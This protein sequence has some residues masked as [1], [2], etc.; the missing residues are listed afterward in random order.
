MA[1]KKNTRPPSTRASRQN[2]ESQRQRLF[3]AHAIVEV[4]RHAIASQLDGLDEAAITNALQ[5]A[6]GIVDDV[7]A[8][9][10]THTMRNTQ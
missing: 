7:A 2:V 3:Q 4:T 8:A 5:V 10:E 6:G 1:A 9:L